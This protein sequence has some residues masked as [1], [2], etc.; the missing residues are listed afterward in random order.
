MFKLPV[1][2][3]EAADC[4]MMSHAGRSRGRALSGSRTEDQAFK[5][6]SLSTCFFHPESCFSMGTNKL[7]YWAIFFTGKALMSRST[8]NVY[9]AS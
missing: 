1:P 6:A 9:F 8:L 4:R 5:E 7:A 3:D 2:L